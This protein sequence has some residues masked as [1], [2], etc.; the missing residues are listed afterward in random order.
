[1]AK[2]AFGVSLDEVVAYR[3][4]V[5]QELSPER[6]EARDRRHELRRAKESLFRLLSYRAYSEAELRSRLRAKQFTDE[7][8]ERALA[9]LRGSGLVDDRQ[10]AETFV[11]G[12]LR[13]VRAGAVSSG[14][15]ARGA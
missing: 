13:P 5:G 10:F 8:I 1:M 3:L 14:S 4:A 2:Y 15:F 7:V 11:A 9:D 6:L 12:S